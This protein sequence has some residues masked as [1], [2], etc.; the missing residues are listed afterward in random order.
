MSALVDAERADDAR[1]RRHEAAAEDRRLQ[2]VVI[3]CDAEGLSMAATQERCG[4]ISGHAVKWLRVRAG[5]AK[6]I[7]TRSA[8]LWRLEAC[9]QR[10]P[11]ARAA[12]KS[13]R[14]LLQESYEQP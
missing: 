8:L 9:V 1:R 5:V 4:G 7:E 10:D 12:L 2:L 14:R 13:L 6:A 3:Q 11:A